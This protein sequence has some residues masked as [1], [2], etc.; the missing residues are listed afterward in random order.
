M[1]LINRPRRLRRTPTL[2]RLVRETQLSAAD[3]IAP[4]FIVEGHD[5]ARSIGSMPGHAQ[6]SVDRIDREIDELAELRV[7]AVLLFGIPMHKDATGTGAWNPEGPVPSAIRA[8]KDRVPEM[9]VVA[10]VC[11]CEY[12]DHGHCGVLSPDSA[13][14]DVDNDPTLDLLARAAVAYADA[15]ADI[16][17][18]SAMMDG[19]VA[20][21]RAGLD[22]AG[23]T[24]VPILA[25]AAK[26]ASA[27]YGPF[28]EAAESTPRFGD[29][30]S[31]QMDPANGRE[32]LREVALDVAEGAD[33]LMVKPAGAYLDIIREVRASY[34]LPLAAYQVSGEYAMLKA[35]AQN[36]WIDERRAALE[37]L[38]AIKRAGADMIITYYAKDAVRWIAE[39]I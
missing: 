20:A 24:T 5:V 39:D 16:V 26:F 14:A 6:L 22:K 37:S 1:T 27:F 2:R 32:A 23:H 11:M 21:I 12:T 9:A 18:P 15:G 28:R 29:R 25:Y 33:M 31:Y 4:L 10:D 30:R 13:R 3:L 7:P 35:A 36:G 8:I 38:I 19:Q 17:A 34:E